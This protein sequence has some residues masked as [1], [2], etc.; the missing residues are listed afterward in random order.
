[1][2]RDAFYRRFSKFSLLAELATFAANAGVIPN[3]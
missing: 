2:P 1:M 3:Y